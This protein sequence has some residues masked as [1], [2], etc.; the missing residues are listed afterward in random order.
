[1][2]IRDLFENNSELED[3]KEGDIVEFASDVHTDKGPCTATVYQVDKNNFSVSQSNS[4]EYEVETFKKSDL[5]LNKHTTHKDGDKDLWIF[6][7]KNVFN[8]EILGE[9]KRFVG[10]NFIFVQILN[11]NPEK[12]RFVVWDKESLKTNPTDEMKVGIVDL[13]IDSQ[14]DIEGLVNI[15][16]FNHKKGKGY[17]QKVI[18]DIINITKDKLKIYDVQKE[19]QKFWEKM[20]IEWTTDKVEG[21]IK[22]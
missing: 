16:I 12:E 19:A 14:D 8:D 10:D 6:E 22:K 4:S 11:T 15:E 17:G 13:V 21:V 9:M 1:M 20:G 2:K 3:I 5:Q 18:E 7:Q